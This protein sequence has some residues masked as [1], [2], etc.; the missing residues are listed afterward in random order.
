MT[1]QTKLTVQD[2]LKEVRIFD[3]T[4]PDFVKIATSLGVDASLATLGAGASLVVAIRN[5]SGEA[6]DSMR[7]LF[8]VDKEGV[9]APRLILQGP[10]AAGKATPA[11]PHE[12]GGAVTAMMHYGPGVGGGHPWPLDFYQG[13]TV[14]ASIDSAT[15]ASGRFVGADTLNF[16]ATLIA[17]Q[18]AKKSFFADL[19]AQSKTLTNSELQQVLTAR[20]SAADAAKGK[21][22][23]LAD[24]NL[25]AMTEFSLSVQALTRLT[26]SGLP[27]LSSW[28]EQENVKLSSQP[29]LHR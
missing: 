11:A 9:H 1:A 23:S 20:Q 3:H 28:A 26:R 14:I 29:T 24:F 12:L 16:F 4:S 18:A 22:T 10:L 27:D 19:A 25:A 2:S 15:L 7:L 6:I 8:Q 13:A 5:D 17:E 21:A